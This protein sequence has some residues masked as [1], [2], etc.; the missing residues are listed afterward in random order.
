[1]SPTSV[2][3][4]PGD[5]LPAAP[6]AAGP[7]SLL[8]RLRHRLPPAGGLRD[9][10]QDHRG[11]QENATGGT[12]PVCPP[13][14]HGEGTSSFEGTKREMLYQTDRFGLS[15]RTVVLKLFLLVYPLLEYKEGVYV[16]QLSTP[17][18]RTKHF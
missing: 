18:T 2:L 6:A 13:P 12:P 14:S 9:G 4:S 10:C 11:V 7:A 5:P 1:M 17:F 3:A 15:S 16:F 8:D